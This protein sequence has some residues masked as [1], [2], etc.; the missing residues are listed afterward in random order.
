MG[1]KIEKTPLSQNSLVRFFTKFGGTLED[2]C[3]ML[4]RNPGKIPSFN[5]SNEAIKVNFGFGG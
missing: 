2:T 5:S 4:R 3:S 1:A